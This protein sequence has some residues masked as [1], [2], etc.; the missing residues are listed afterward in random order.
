MRLLYAQELVLAFGVGLGLASYRLTW[1]DWG[2]TFGPLSWIDWF[3]VGIDSIFAGVGLVSGLATF[4]E[5][6]RRSSRVPWGPGR[7]AWA[8]VASYL[9]LTLF[10]EALGTIAI[11]FTPGI[12]IQNSVTTDILNGVRGRYGE[13]LFPSMTWFLLALGLTSLAV[14]ATRTNVCDA[15]EWCGR[16][17]AGLLVTTGLALRA[18][19]LLGF[20]HQIMGGGM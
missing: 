10:D 18:L 9:L 6:V 11:R 15:R 20:R 4:V 16:V 1:P 3:E 13:F 8:V 17:F 19:L 2:E 7:W 12:F 5:Q 14:R